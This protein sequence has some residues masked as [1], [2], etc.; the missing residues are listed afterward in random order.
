MILT[1]TGFWLALANRGDIHHEAAKRA[2]A[3]VSEPLV[4]TLP[5]ATETCHLLLSRLGPS[6]QLAFVASWTAG[7]F[8]LHEIGDHHA[9]RISVLMQKYRELPMD[10]A[11]ASLVIAAEDLGT[12][13]IF[14]TDCRDFRSYRWKNRKPFKNLL[15]P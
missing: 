14:S 7:A 4:T 5:V 8:Q 2:L 13:R 15:L 11:D 9:D 6:A 3:A 1:D 10:L 12:G